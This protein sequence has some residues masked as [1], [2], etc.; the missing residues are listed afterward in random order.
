MGRSFR[1][2]PAK[3]TAQWAKVEALFR[4]GFRFWSYGTDAPALPATLA[5]VDA[6]IRDNPDHPMRIGQKASD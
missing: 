1:A 2:P 3:D 4:A 5:E 6:F